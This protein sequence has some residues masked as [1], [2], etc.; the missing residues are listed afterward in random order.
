MTADTSNVIIT[1]QIKKVGKVMNQY[2]ASIKQIT[3]LAFEGDDVVVSFNI[4]P[5]SDE[6]SQ[7]LGDIFVLRR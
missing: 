7:M 3:T 6:H 5:E 1:M 4:D 2:L